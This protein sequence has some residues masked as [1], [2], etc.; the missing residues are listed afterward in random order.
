MF[1]IGLVVGVIIGSTVG[2]FATAFCVA[3]KRGE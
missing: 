2:L 1:W 3:A